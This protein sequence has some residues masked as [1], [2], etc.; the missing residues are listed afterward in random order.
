MLRFFYLYPIMEKFFKKFKNAIFADTLSDNQK[1][2]FGVIYVSE[3]YACCTHLCP[4]GCGTEICI[5]IKSDEITTWDDGWDYKKN[6]SNEITLSPSL[7]NKA[8]PIRSHYFI[9]NNKI[10]YV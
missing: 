3:K 9:K 5:P 8:C 7:L 2:E 6:I 10:E 1:L 4:C